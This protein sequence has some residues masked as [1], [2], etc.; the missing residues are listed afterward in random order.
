LRAT[1]EALNAKHALAK[2]AADA[3]AHLQRV[4]GVREAL[5][6][7]DEDVRLPARLRVSEALQGLTEW[8][9]CAVHPLDGQKV[10]TIAMVGG[11]HTMVLN[12]DGSIHFH[13]RPSG[14][15]SPSDFADDFDPPHIR[16]RMDSYMRRLKAQAA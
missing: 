13:M 5:G 1:H 11:S 3:E 7:P 10:T 15:Q 14:D 2:G 16:E 9:A 8:V 6:H 12:N 4:H